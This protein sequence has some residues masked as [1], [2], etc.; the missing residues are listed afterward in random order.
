MVCL[1]DYKMPETCEDCTLESYCSLWVD[2]RRTSDNGERATTRHQDCPLI[3]VPKQKH[4]K[5]EWDHHNGYSYC[6][7][8]NS[9][10]P[11]EDQ[12]GEYCDEPNYC[13]NCGADMRGDSN[14]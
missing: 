1:K 7:C 9:V 13:P 2:A 10:S 5:W 4:G 3:E 6:S 11:H 14:V 8:C 12:Y